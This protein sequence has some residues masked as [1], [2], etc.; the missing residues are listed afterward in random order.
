M[1]FGGGEVPHQKKCHFFSSKIFE[2]F[3]KMYIFFNQNCSNLHE[4]CEMCWIESKI[5]F[6]GFFPCYGQFCSPIFG[7]FFTITRKIKI[8]KLIFHSIQHIAHL[9]LKWEQNWR[10]GL[11]IPTWEIPEIRKNTKSF[12]HFS[13]I[14]CTVFRPITLSW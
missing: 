10:R 1:V 13:P 2:Y 14:S 5:W 8:R 9:S 12:V 7:Q 4:K 3:K 6:F 11:Y